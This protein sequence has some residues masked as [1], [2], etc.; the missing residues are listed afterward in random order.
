MN[1]P[2]PRLL[3]ACALLFAFPLA[4]AVVAHPADDPAKTQAAMPSP[5]EDEP[6]EAQQPDAP[7]EDEV[8]AVVEE[9]R[10]C[11][12]VRLETA[13]RRKTKL[14]R[15]TEEWRQLNNPR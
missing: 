1:I 5:Q 14:C 6:T 4:G 13:T 8:E 15:T 7:A 10:I 12:Y 9:K 2:R 11:R 3:S